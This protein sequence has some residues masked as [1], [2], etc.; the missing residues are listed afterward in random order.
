M[1]GSSFG[2][3]FLM[4]FSSPKFTHYLDSLC[5]KFYYEDFLPDGVVLLSYDSGFMCGT[6]R[7][8]PS[9]GNKPYTEFPIG[10]RKQPVSA[11]PP[12][13]LGTQEARTGLHLGSYNVLPS[14]LKKMKQS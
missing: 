9:Y 6:N 5:S 11:F 12:P 8:Q 10:G 14:Y 7:L 13:V 3:Y 4:Y 1:S 2:P